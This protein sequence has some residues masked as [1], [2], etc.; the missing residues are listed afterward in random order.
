MDDEAPVAR[1][2]ETTS[3]EDCT[4]VNSIHESAATEKIDAAGHRKCRNAVGLCALCSQAIEGHEYRRGRSR[5][6]LSTFGFSPLN[7]VITSVNT[8][9]SV[10]MINTT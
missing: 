4:D 9:A 8:V 10:T 5:M 3:Y 2:C 7:I 1:M 6:F